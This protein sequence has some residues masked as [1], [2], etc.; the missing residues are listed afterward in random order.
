MAYPGCYVVSFLLQVLYGF[1]YY[2]SWR[3]SKCKLKLIKWMRQWQL[4]ASVFFLCGQLVSVVYMAAEVPATSLKNHLLLYLIIFDANIGIFVVW[5][6]VWNQRKWARILNGLLK[7]GESNSPF[8]MR[9]Y[10]EW[11]VCL[12]MYFFF[13]ASIITNNLIENHF[14]FLSLVYAIESVRRNI[15]LV[16]VILYFD[17]SIQIL[18]GYMKKCAGTHSSTL[19]PLETAKKI[20]HSVAEVKEIALIIWESIKMVIAMIIVGDTIELIFSFSSMVSSGR[21]T[22][23][24][25]PYVG[26]GVIRIVMILKSPADLQNSVGIQNSVSYWKIQ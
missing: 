8:P 25:F 7:L 11:T 10:V 4:L 20:V 1:P 6:L 17:L 14:D 19:S 12:T 15:F 9:K 23:K 24:D 16:I 22:G 2:F 13:T 3:N 5:Y 26:M 21:F 18:I